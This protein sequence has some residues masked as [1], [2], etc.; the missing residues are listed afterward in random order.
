MYGTSIC[1]DYNKFMFTH[2]AVQVW[3]SVPSA[4]VNVICMSLNENSVYCILFIYSLRLIH[5]NRVVY[6]PPVA[7]FGAQSQ[8][9]SKKT[10][11]FIIHKPTF[12]Q[13]FPAMLSHVITAQV[14]RFAPIFEFVLH[15]VG[16][17]HERSTPQFERSKQGLNR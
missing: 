9:P 4:I 2:K 15:L 6:S 17:L 8:H 12:N 1:T 13:R 16:W 10:P 3:E 11:K 5:L 7:M 14:P